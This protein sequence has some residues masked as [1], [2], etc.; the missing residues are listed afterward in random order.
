MMGKLLTILVISIC[1]FP[2]TARS[3]ECVEGDCQNGTGAMIYSTGHRFTGG[4]KD[5]M[6]HGEGV[7]LLPGSRKLVGVWENNE[8]KEGTFTDADGTI[9]TGQWQFREREGQGTMTW[10]D[11]RKY[12]GSF[13][14]GL[15]HGKGT[16]IY[17]DGRKYEGEF[18]YG[19]RS[20]NG[21]MTYPDGRKYIGEFKDG[22]RT[23]RGKLIYPD[24]RE[25]VGEFK[26]GEFVGK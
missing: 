10:P 9:Y 7:L 25:Q 26:N 2:L 21:T 17:P 15:R 6:R 19:E 24:G 22:E 5:G 23:G 11:G 20:G 8:I 14:N 13:D 1:L 12:T 18:Q 4:F 16:M 3:D